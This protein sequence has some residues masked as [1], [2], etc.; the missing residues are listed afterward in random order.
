VASAHLL[1]LLLVQSPAGAA[2]LNPQPCQTLLLL[3]DQRP[4]AHLN[5]QPSQTLLHL[6]QE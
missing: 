3:L 4:A 2:H 1:L 6:Q 5:P